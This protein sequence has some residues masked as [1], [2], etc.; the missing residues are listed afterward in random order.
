MMQESKF[1]DQYKYLG[2]SIDSN[3]EWQEHVEGAPH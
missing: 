1:F 3:L 2:V